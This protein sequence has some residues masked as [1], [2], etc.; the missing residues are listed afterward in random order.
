M[1]EGF[2]RLLNEEW[3]GTLMVSYLCVMALVT[4]IAATVKGRSM[5]WGVPCVLF[6]PFLILLIRLPTTKRAGQVR[7]PSRCGNDDF[8]PSF[9]CRN[10][11]LSSLFRSAMSRYYVDFMLNTELGQYVQCRLD[12]FSI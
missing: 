5:L 11:V 8:N 1:H 3:F 6:P 10:P 2:G 12:D 7:C 4:V 9:L